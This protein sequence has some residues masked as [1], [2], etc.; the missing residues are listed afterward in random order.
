MK[1]TILVF[2]LLTTGITILDYANIPSLMGLNMSNINWDFY[3]GALNVIA[4]II[5]FIIT[6]ETLN[7]REIEINEQEMAREKNKYD[8]SFMLLKSCYE[9]CISYINLLN[10][11]LVEKYIIPKVDFNSSE[12]KIVN[13][14]QTAP[15][16][17]ENIILELVKDGQ[18]TENVVAGYFNIKRRYREYVNVRIT[19]FDAPQ[20]YTPLKTKL[21]TLLND[22]IKMVTQSKI[23]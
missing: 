16:I 21:T 1:K 22:E 15:F 14:L 5:I 11:E 10:D 20:V 23:N 8:I 18:I 13:N 9:E 4:V 3:M 19:L 7:R 12:S 6:F 17:N 2:L